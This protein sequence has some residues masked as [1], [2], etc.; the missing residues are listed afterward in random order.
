MNLNEIK[1]YTLKI[2][3]NF[4]EYLFGNIDFSPILKCYKVK[5]NVNFE[6]IEIDLYKNLSTDIKITFNYFEIFIENVEKIN[7]LKNILSKYDF[8]DKNYIYNQEAKKL[9]LKYNYQLFKKFVLNKTYDTLKKKIRNAEIIKNE[10]DILIKIPKCDQQEYFDF[11]D[12]HFIINNIKIPAKF[13]F[14]EIKDKNIILT[15][16]EETYNSVSKIMK[17]GGIAILYL[18]G[19]QVFFFDIKKQKLSYKIT[20]SDENLK[21]INLLFSLNLNVENLEN[22]ER[23]FIRIISFL[24]FYL[25]LL[26]F[27]LLMIRSR[28]KE[29]ELLSL[30]FSFTFSSLLMG[31]NFKLLLFL[32]INFILSLFKI[33]K[34]YKLLLSFLTLITYF[35]SI[36]LSSIG[37]SLLLEVLVLWYYGL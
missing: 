12:P 13:T 2:G 26:I 36:N 3:E 11:Y 33:K 5:P 28:K 37:I 6:E 31:I 27:I 1:N 8:I 16:S 21:K 35:F 19:K 15:L 23:N 30:F 22:E 29:K 25:L 20:C 4:Y 14:F 9:T 24:L 34:K 7:S 10:D 18:N 17:F 32:P